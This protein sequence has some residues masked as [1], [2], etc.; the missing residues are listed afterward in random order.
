MT[1][2]EART[3]HVHRT[4]R[5]GILARIG[6]W[7]AALVADMCATDET[8]DDPTASFSSREWADLPT[9]HPASDE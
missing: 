1:L 3:T 5:P 7:L 2:I 6:T 8:S 4:D 9:H